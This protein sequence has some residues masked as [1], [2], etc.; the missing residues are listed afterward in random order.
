MGETTG[1]RISARVVSVH[2]GD[3]ITILDEVEHKIRLAGIDAPEIGQEFGSASKRNLSSL[4]LNKSVTVLTNKTDRNGRI[5]GKVLSDG[6]DVNLEQV[7]TGLAWHYKKYQNEQALS[8]RS[9]YSEAEK[10][11]QAKRLGL[12]SNLSSITPEEYR[13]SSGLEN[14]ADVPV[15]SI[16]GNK[17]SM[18][19]HTP[20]C[21]TYTKVSPQNQ[22]LFD[23]AREAEA[24]GFRRAKNCKE[25]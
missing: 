17:N 5:V 11:A 10:D 21:S 2:D 6:V 25:G 20:G 7:K 8:D 18:I 24:A 23:N 9:A 15:G 19:Y 3:T 12:W 16:I 1:H 22:T 13:K 4:I 14:I